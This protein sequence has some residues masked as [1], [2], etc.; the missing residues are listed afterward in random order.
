MA[1]AEL[2]EGELHAYIDDELDAAARARVAAL[3]DSSPALARQAELFAADKAR[4]GEVFAGLIDQPLPPRLLRALQQPETVVESLAARRRSGWKTW[5]SLAA[6]AS[7]LLAIGLGVATLRT[8][9]P[10][11]ALV[12]EA[13]ATHSDTPAGAVTSGDADRLLSGTLGLPLKS[14][15][16]SKAGYSLAAAVVHG[17]S[18]Q[19]RA[20]TLRYRDGQGRIFSILVHRSIGADRFEMRSDGAL[21]IC[22]WQ[23]DEVST[24]MLGNL[25]TSEMLRVA[26]LTYTALSL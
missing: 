22:I 10:T 15:D 26:S 8:T 16:L 23:N 12:A 2:T 19:G 20:V 25:S 21:K 14:P 6:A 9:D 3:L 7:L 5:G 11:D 17:D 24:V 1:R 4:L 18:Q 13:I